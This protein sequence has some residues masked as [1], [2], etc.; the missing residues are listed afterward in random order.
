MSA[1]PTCWKT[2]SP[3]F[4]DVERLAVAR[5]ISP[6]HIPAQLLCNTWGEVV[7]L[8]GHISLLNHY[9]RWVGD[10]TAIRSCRE[11]G[12]RPALVGSLPDGLGFRNSEMPYCSSPVT[13]RSITLVALPCVVTAVTV[14]DVTLLPTLTV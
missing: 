7:S 14:V 1:A 5:I 12:N 3:T 6:V 9:G 8:F 4:A 2:R 10:P 11:F 13:W